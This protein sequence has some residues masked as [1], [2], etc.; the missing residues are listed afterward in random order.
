MNKRPP[1]LPNKVAEMLKL[2]DVEAVFVPS[3]RKNSGIL[4]STPYFDLRMREGVRPRGSVTVL[5]GKDGWTYKM[6]ADAVAEL[7]K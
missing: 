6:F 1:P 4:W 7:L 5:A 3:R 2:A